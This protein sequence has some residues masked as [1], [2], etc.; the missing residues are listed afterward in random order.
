MEFPQEAGDLGG[1]V[2]Q[3]GV[4]EAGDGFLI[5][6]FPGQHPIAG[7]SAL[8]RTGIDMHDL[9]VGGRQR[10][11]PP[12]GTQEVDFGPQRVGRAGRARKSEDEGI[13]GDE[14]IVELAPSQLDRRVIRY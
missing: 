6:R 4:R 10:Q 9:G 2:R 12:E 14:D 8:R 13:V 11:A 3:F 1:N 7:E 5:E